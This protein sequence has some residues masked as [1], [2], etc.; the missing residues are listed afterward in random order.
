M[1]K[2]RKPRT[3]TER[4]WNKFIKEKHGN[5][6][7]P[8][9]DWYIDKDGNKIGSAAECMRPWWRHCDGNIFKCMKLKQQHLA[10]RGK[11]EPDFY[12]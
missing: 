11:N 2:S 9:Y 8:Y 1:I 10:S 6:E 3:A 5:T 4:F 7:C 12:E